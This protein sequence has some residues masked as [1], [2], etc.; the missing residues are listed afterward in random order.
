MV[1]G[2]GAIVIIILKNQLN[3]H[4]VDNRSPRYRE[5]HHFLPNVKQGNYR[6]PNKF[7]DAMTSGL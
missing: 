6:H 5:E 7:R 1:T 3:Q 4:H 2:D